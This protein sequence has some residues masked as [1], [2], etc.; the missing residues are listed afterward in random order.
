MKLM[1][2]C[3]YV[4]VYVY[5]VCVHVCLCVH[6]WTKYFGLTKASDHKKTNEKTMKVSIAV[7][8]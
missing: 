5:C 4:H 2:I 8:S 7:Y 1:L 3:E 6:R